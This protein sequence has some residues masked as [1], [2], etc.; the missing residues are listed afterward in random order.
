LDAQGAFEAQGA[1]ALD[2]QGAF[3][4]QGAFVVLAG[5]VVVLGTS[6]AEGFEQPATAPM[7]NR[8]AVAKV[9]K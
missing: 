8:D 4:A 5:A 7:P 3:E 1:F 6:F 2:A 9:S